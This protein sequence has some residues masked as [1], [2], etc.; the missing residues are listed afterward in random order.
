MRKEIGSA[1]YLA[2]LCL[3]LFL[4][5]W[6]PKNWVLVLFSFSI[7]L[8]AALLEYRKKQILYLESLF[9]VFLLAISYFKSRHESLC[10]N[11]SLYLVFF[12]ISGLNLFLLIQRIFKA[13]SAGMDF[14]ISGLNGYL[15]TGFIF[16]VLCS[17]AEFVRPGSFLGQSAFDFRD[18]HQF[19]YFSFV[20]FLT[21][22]Y[23][24]ILPVSGLAKS[25]SVFIGLFGTF[26][27]TLVLG[28]VLGKYFKTQRH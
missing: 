2:G 23:G 17:Y 13:S 28:L 11:H 4:P 1:I 12:V 5:I 18:L 10:L 27:L 26:Y 19:V 8:F 3:F 9:L 7:T 15:L 21:L 22:G 14:I 24:D 6:L 16:S 25:L 20:T